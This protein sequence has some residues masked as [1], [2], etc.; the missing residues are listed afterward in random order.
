[1]RLFKAMI[2]ILLLSQPLILQARGGGG[3][4]LG[5]GSASYYS[6]EFAGR[7][8][9]NGE[10]FNP[11]ALTAAH[12]T[13]SFGSKIHVT[14]LGNGKEVVVRVNDRGPWTRGRIIDL[15]HAAAKKLGMLS[16]GTARVK[17]VL[18]PD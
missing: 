7:R 5:T 12:R 3:T 11:K 15:S 17:L 2:V 14:N 1:M 18:L 16:S 8:T 10:S 9:A 13:A 6:N 4:N